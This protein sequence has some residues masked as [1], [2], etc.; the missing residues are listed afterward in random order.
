[1]TIETLSD[2][3]RRR[4]SDERG[5]SD[6]TCSDYRWDDIVEAELVA[7]GL[8]FS[9]TTLPNGKLVVYGVNPNGQ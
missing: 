8:N 5:F 3:L 4:I 2:W 9:I 6:Y 7:A 1:M